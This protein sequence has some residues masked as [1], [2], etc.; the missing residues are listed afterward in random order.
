VLDDAVAADALLPENGSEDAVARGPDPAH[1]RGQVSKPYFDVLG[2]ATPG[3][4]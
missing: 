2:A 1:M 3:R 4:L